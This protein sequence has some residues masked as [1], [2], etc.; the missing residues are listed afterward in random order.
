MNLMQQHGSEACG[1][2]VKAVEEQETSAGEADEEGTGP[3]TRIRSGPDC[4]HSGMLWT[5]QQRP[6][7]D[8]KINF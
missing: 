3:I 7:L 8:P 5:S 2:A 1:V 6:H 4:S